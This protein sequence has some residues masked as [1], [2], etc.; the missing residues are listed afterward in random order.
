MLPP[1]YQWRDADSLI[2]RGWWELLNE[3]GT[4]AALIQPHAG[5]FYI[6]VHLDGYAHEVKHG[7]AVTL[8]RAKMHVERWAEGRPG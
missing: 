3:A 4:K 8:D 5:R 6:T 7:S 1:G 2:T